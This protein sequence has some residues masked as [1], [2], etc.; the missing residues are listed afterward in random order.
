M[1]NSPPCWTM[2]AQRAMFH[3]LAY[4]R[5]EACIKHTF[6]FANGH[7]NFRFALCFSRTRQW[8][9]SMS[10]HNN[11]K[12]FELDWIRTGLVRRTQLSF[13]FFF[14]FFFFETPVRSLHI[15]PRSS[16][17]VRNCKSRLEVINIIVCKVWKISLVY[18]Y[19]TLHEKTQLKLRNDFLS[20]VPFSSTL[21]IFCP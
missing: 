13:F 5:A 10:T 18:I 11:H 6:H 1:R 2:F 16:I 3:C 14:F 9:I 19:V 7:Q 20:Y 21:A 4:K 17:L 15:R 8:E 12:Q